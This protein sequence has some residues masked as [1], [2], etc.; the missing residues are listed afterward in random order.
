MC[1]LVNPT[2]SQCVV[3]NHSF[4][5]ATA[6]VGA[7]APR[8]Q[9]FRAK[10]VARS[11]ES[12]LDPPCWKAAHCRN[13]DSFVWI[14]PLVRQR[15]EQSTWQQRVCRLVRRP[16]R[17]KTLEF[18]PSRPGAELSKE[19]HNLPENHGP[20]DDIIHDQPRPIRACH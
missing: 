7:N 11:H 2:D 17:H 16:W 20:R 8:V 10:T 4:S 19:K 6:F 12:W 13:Q 18:P 9:K 3:D 15:D 14:V 5:K 1:W